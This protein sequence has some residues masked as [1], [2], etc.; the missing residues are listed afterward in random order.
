MCLTYIIKIMITLDRNKTI[1]LTGHRPKEMLSHCQTDIGLD[2]I[3]S[4]AAKQILNLY[5]HGY[6]TFLSDMTQGFGLLAAEIV[7]HYVVN[8]RHLTDTGN[9]IP[10]T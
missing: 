2:Q 8:A 5:R 4:D 3:R 1:A 6:N 10:R 9:I 7:C